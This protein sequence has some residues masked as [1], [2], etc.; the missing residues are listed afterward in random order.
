MI[1]KK[2]KK[3][4]IRAL[5]TDKENRNFELL[6]HKLVTLRI[7]KK[8]NKWMAQIA[9]TIP[10]V[11]GTGLKIMGVD[12]DIKVPIVAVTDDEKVC[13]FGNG[14]QNKYIRRM[15][16]SKHKKLGKLKKL[17]A[18]RNLDDKEQR[19]MKDQDHKI[20]R[21]IV[22]FAKE[23]KISVIRLEQLANIRQTERTSRKN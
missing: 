9:V 19:Y 2:V 18:I 6:K 22:N 10:T 14:R 23:N 1:N 5:L 3:T 7:T 12:L 11:E 8:S 13:F 21:A 17:N 20:S 16:K 15:F 4:P